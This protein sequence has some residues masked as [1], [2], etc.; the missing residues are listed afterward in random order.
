MRGIF[1][2]HFFTLHRHVENNRAQ[3]KAQDKILK[4]RRFC[5]VEKC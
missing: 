5:S 4:M 1:F 3:G 2:I